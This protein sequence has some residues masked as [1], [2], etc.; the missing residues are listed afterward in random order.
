MDGTCSGAA[1][2][3][4]I[5]VDQTLTCHSREAGGA[6]PR[7]QELGGPSTRPGS[8]ARNR[9]GRANDVEMVA[10]PHVA[11]PQLPD[12]GDPDCGRVIARADSR[13]R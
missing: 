12:L 7:I 10:D 5:C 9:N 4:L 6:K 2:E 11:L 13:L 3:T 1:V 8:R